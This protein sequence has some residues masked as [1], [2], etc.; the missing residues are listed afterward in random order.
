METLRRLNNLI[1]I[2][3]IVETKS[4]EGKALAR[5]NING[6]VTDFLPALMVNNDFVKVWVPARVKEQVT[7]LSPF[8]N[9]DFGVIL[10]AIYNVGNKEPAGANANNVIVEVGNVR[11]ETDG[12]SV[13][14]S[15]PLSVNINTPVVNMSGNLVVAGNITDSRG[16]L[17]GHTH[18]TTDGATAE[19]R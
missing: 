10:P 17:T 2:G 1:Q 18:S 9:A 7:V 19:A 6:R 8:G 13:D 3:T 4:V 14:I 5:V 16:D 11:V 12:Q 15:A